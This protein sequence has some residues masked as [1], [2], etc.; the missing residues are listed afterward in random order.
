MNKTIVIPITEEDRNTVQR[1]DVDASATKDIITTILSRDLP[2]PQE[3]L[4]NYEA[5]YRDQYFAFEK[6]KQE[7]EDKYIRSNPEMKDISGIINWNL[8]YRKCE[9]SVTI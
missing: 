2:I 3:R 1:A 4:D 6:A 5:K 9:I 8:D 7:L